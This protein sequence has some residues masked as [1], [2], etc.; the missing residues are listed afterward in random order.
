[1]IFYQDNEIVVRLVN[2]DF[3]GYYRFNTSSG[4][5]TESSR[6][7]ESECALHIK[8]NKSGDFCQGKK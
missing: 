3:P 5:Q 6:R 7:P 4:K 2:G 1:M 8:N